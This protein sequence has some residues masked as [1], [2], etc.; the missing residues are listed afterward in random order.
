MYARNTLTFDLGGDKD[1]PSSEAPAYAKRFAAGMDR[2]FSLV[3]IAEYF[4]ESLVLL[5]RLLSWDL[6]DVLYISL[7]M[8]T[9]DSKSSLSSE[10]MSK[11]R[12][13]NAIDSVLYDH[14]N[15]SL[16]QQLRALGLAC[17]E[18]EVQLLRQSRDRLIRSCFGGHL[19]PT[20]L[21]C[22]DHE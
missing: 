12:A 5:R 19:P 16:W 8:R 14:F 4:D 9:P 17:V 15:A 21:S 2:V 13:W 3:M 10:N 6:N 18:R 1:W 7:N 20:S 22:T 11:I